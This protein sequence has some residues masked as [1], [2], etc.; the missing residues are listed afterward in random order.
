MKWKN[1]TT[2]QFCQIVTFMRILIKNVRY[3]KK[4]IQD[5]KKILAS[6]AKIIVPS[7]FYHGLIYCFSLFSA[8][9]TN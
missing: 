8:K 3:L 4:I 7:T 1:V 5:F 9:R 6:Q 2:F